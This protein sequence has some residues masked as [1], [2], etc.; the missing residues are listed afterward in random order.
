MANTSTSFVISMS[1]ADFEALSTNDMSWAGNNWEQRYPDRFMPVDADEPLSYAWRYV[2][3]FDGWGDVILARSFLDARG[4]RY[5]VCSA[6]S[7]GKEPNAGPEYVVLTDYHPH[8]DRS[9]PGEAS[10]GDSPR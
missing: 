4:H 3:W 5:Q 10:A 1:D 2:H 9:T 8:A 7:L 6:E